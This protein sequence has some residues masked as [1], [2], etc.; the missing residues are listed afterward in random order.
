MVLT[1]KVAFDKFFIVLKYAI[2]EGE[3][4]AL[5]VS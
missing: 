5:E 2:D 3:E 1:S 4:V